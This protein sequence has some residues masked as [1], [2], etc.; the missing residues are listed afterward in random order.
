[1]NS[2]TTLTVK[3]KNKKELAAIKK[4]LVGFNVDF[5]TND[6]IEKPYNQEFVDKILQ[7]KEEFKQGKFKTIDSVDLWK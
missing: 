5:D 4:I 6:D 2:M 7:S 1:M 3:P